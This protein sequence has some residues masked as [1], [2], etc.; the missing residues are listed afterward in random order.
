MAAKVER[1]PRG[2]G[3]A[4][5]AARPPGWPP[6]PRRPAR[7][8]WLWPT[9]AIRPRAASRSASA[10]GESRSGPGPHTRWRG[11]TGPLIGQR[12]G[13]RDGPA[14]PR[15]DI[16]PPPP[17]WSATGLAPAAASPPGGGGRRLASTVPTVAPLTMAR[18]GQMV[19]GV[20]WTRSARPAW[21]NRR[22]IQGTAAPACPA[23]TAPTP[24]QPATPSGRCGSPLRIASD[25]DVRLCRHPGADGGLLTV[26]PQAT[27]GPDLTSPARQHT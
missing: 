9:S 24:A 15:S 21:R 8:P 6:A 23:P 7:P 11:S 3:S 5:P 13:S 4:G 2:P 16:G 27:T 18:V 14:A 20:S 10:A 22:S 12:A 26:I 17:W 25:R 1:A 19:P